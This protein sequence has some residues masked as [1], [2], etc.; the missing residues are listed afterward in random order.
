M[1]YLL[2]NNS[3]LNSF[4]TLN[5]NSIGNKII[6]SKISSTL[7]NKYIQNYNI[8]KSLYSTKS[9]LSR[10]LINGNVNS[11]LINSHNSQKLFLKN[12]YVLSNYI[13]STSA[14]INLFQL[15]CYSTK[16]KEKDGDNDNSTNKDKGNNIDKENKEEEEDN[17]KSISDDNTENANKDKLDKSSSKSN[18]NIEKSNKNEIKKDENKDKEDN[19]DNEA[20]NN[21]FNDTSFVS[22]VKR[23]AQLL[24]LDPKMH[25]SPQEK[26]EV[27]KEYPQVMALPLTRRPLFPG[28][29]KTLF[30]K[31]PKVI[32]AIN[33][34]MA[35]KQPF[36]SVFMTKDETFDG[37][38]VNDMS[39]IYD[40]GVFAQ[41]SNVYH[42]GPDNKGL[43]ILLYP[44]RRIK[45]KNL[46][47]PLK[48]EEMEDSADNKTIK[49]EESSKKNA[50]ETE[51]RNDNKEENE[52]KEEKELPKECNYYKLY[53]YIIFIFLLTTYTY[54]Y[55]YKYFYLFIFLCVNY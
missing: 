3:N 18:D 54:I 8:N 20:K 42:S 15:N 12:E 34:L 44:H 9:T 55:I 10:N 4:S 29:Y 37:D 26:I 53:V 11:S 19:K 23:L 48:K 35:R 46:I 7:T 47:P 45:I 6:S 22:E 51:N 36:I 33:D 49:K 1:E 24:D 2:K 13:S 39:Q 40:V 16:N 50:N 25:N 30:V 38:V 52:N 27:P 17:S 14:T 31:D 41:I 28:F 43:T 32:N 21:E 5:Q